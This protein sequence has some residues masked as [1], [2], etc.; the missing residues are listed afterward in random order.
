[1]NFYVVVE[2]SVEKKVYG[3]WIPLMNPSLKQ[4]NS[5]GE[6]T[7][8]NFIIFDGGGYPYI[9]ELIEN[10][11]SDLAHTNNDYRLVVIIDSEDMSRQEKFSEIDAFI[12]GKT[13][14]VHLDYRIIVQHF[15][16][17]TW[18][19]G[20]R[21]IVTSNPSNPELVEYLKHYHVRKNDPEL[22]TVIPKSNLNRAQFAESYLRKLL[23]QKF[24]QTYTKRNPE[25]VTHPTYFAELKNR[26]L[27]TGHIGSF[28]DLLET[29]AP[30]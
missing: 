11:I 21:K 4:I 22:L 19:L 30:I 1:V 16:F 29:F 14:G 6:T 10:G 24:H 5:L 13:S 28:K 2:G 12:Q 3:K 17:E 8:D 26:L 25:A 23:Q 15:C 9:L 7:Q 27:D 18:A 20:N